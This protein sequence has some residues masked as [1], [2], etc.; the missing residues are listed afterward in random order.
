MDQDD[1]ILADFVMRKVEEDEAYCEEHRYTIVCNEEVADK[2][3]A[4]NQSPAD[5][6]RISRF[7]V[8]QGLASWVIKDPRLLPEK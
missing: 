6:R 1:Q 8:H 5:Q 4:A 3:F 2:Y 7:L